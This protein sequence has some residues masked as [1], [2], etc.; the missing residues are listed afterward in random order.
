MI[1]LRTVLLFLLLLCAL[2]WLVAYLPASWVRPQ[3]EARLHGLR[4]EGLSGTLWDGHAE[5]V[6]A[7]SGGDLGQFDWQLSRRALLGETRLGVAFRGPWGHL[8]GQLRQLEGKREEWSQ[9]QLDGDLATLSARLAPQADRLDGRLSIDNA[10]IV[11]QGR[12]PVELD[13]AAQWTGARL[14]GAQ[15]ELVFGNLQLRAS[16]TAGVVNA[17]LEDD[18]NGP[19]QLAGHLALSPLGWKYDIKARPREPDPALR[20]W[21]SGFGRLAADGSMHLQR[22][23]G[24]AAIMGKGKQ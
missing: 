18:G 13:A 1:R 22:S 14:Q 8:S 5:R 6:L 20:D 17:T 15:R 16:G 21:L 4:L 12:W 24:L 19:L 23:G 2:A 11:L 3:L 9:V 7:P 10:R